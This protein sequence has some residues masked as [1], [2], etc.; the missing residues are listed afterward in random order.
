MIRTI[1]ISV[2][3]LAM[4]A[5][6]AASTARNLIVN[7]SFETAGSTE[8]SAAG[9]IY[10]I[11]AE[12]NYSVPGGDADMVARY[13]GADYVPLGA[14]GTP[15]ELSNH[16]IALGS[17][18]SNAS[19]SY[20]QQTF[21][22]KLGETYDVS[23]DVGQLGNFSYFPFSLGTTVTYKYYDGRIVYASVEYADDSAKGYDLGSIFTHRSYSFFG[24]GTDVTISLMAI[25][26]GVPV[27]IVFDNVVVTERGAPAVPEPATWVMMIAGFGLIGAALRRRAA[28]PASA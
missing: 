20:A 24:T 16:F 23:Y 6:A 11:G 8:R 25:I 10:T 19:R 2:F 15:A 28:M 5:P 9:W 12:P 27:S 22:T 7:G 1:A 18:Y 13:S 14:N 21:N 26:R 4:T 17:N 3:T